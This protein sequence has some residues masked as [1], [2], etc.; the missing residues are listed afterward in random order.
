MDVTNIK[1]PNVNKLENLTE[2]ITTNCRKN[3]KL[4]I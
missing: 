1:D 2:K 4:M 3:A